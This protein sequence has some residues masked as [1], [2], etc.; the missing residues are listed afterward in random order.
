[1]PPITLSLGQDAFV[2]MSLEP[3]SHYTCRSNGQP[4]YFVAI[5]STSMVAASDDYAEFW[6][7]A[8]YT[9]VTTA[10]EYQFAAI[11]GAAAP[12]TA[13]PLDDPGAQIVTLEKFTP[14]PFV[15]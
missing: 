6:G 13:L 1:M 7:G 15:G 9:L 4:S 10:A 11:G 8:L 3:S 5:D 14:E 12:D 2:A